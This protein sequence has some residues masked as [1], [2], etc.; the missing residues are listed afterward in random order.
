MAPATHSQAHEETSEARLEGSGNNTGT[1]MTMEAFM[2]ALAIF[3][4]KNRPKVLSVMSCTEQEKVTFPAYMLQEDAYDWWLMVQRQHE[5][6]TRPFTWKMFM[7]AFNNK[8]FP[9]SIRQQKERE[10]LKL[11]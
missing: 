3:G 1:P 6:D 5:K 2:Q 11:E 8:Y 9:K 7:E 4:Q 10:F